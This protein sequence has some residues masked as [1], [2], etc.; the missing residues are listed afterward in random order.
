MGNHF[1]AQVA[2]LFALEA[3]VHDAEGPVGQI[4]DRTAKSLVKRHVG[5]PKAGKAGG[6]AQSLRKS[7]AQGEATVLGCVVIVDCSPR[8]MSVSKRDLR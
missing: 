1:T 4:H 8:R 5:G 2:N 6:G 3:Q 7:I